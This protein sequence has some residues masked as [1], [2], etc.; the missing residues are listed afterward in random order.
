MPAKKAVAKPAT[1]RYIR[2]YKPPGYI[3]QPLYAVPIYAAA[4][5]GDAAEMK[6]L[7]AAARKHLKD[8]TSA[9]ATLEKTIAK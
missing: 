2:P 4:K 8:V 1:K 6:K 7:A 9:L 5:K 3:I